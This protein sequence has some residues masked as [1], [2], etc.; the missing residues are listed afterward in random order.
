MKIVLAIL[1]LVFGYDS[2]MEKYFWDINGCQETREATLNTFSFLGSVINGDQTASNT[3]SAMQGKLG[4]SWTT[5]KNETLCIGNTPAQSRCCAYNQGRLIF[6]IASFV[7]G[8]GEVKVAL[9]AANIATIAAEVATKMTGLFSRIS[10]KAGSSLLLKPIKQIGLVLLTSATMAISDPAVA[11]KSVNAIEQVAIKTVGVASAE[12]VAEA[13]P[14]LAKG[15][16]TV[17]AEAES[18]LSKMPSSIDGITIPV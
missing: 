3:L 7:Y 2:I 6:D 18:I 5:W 9:K 4:E 17:T 8:I 1:G 11:I 13:T 12:M 14:T 15:V 10:I 16:G